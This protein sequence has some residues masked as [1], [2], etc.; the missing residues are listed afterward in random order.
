[1]LTI[2]F[3]QR[4]KTFG[5]KILRN[6]L[7]CEYN[8]IGMI[9]RTSNSDNNLIILEATGDEGVGLLSWKTF[10]KRNWQDLYYKISLRKLQVERTDC[11]L[12]KIESFIR[13]RINFSPEN[14]R[15]MDRINLTFLVINCLFFP[16]LV[17]NW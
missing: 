9:L 1:M 14:F 6:V 15:W 8:H 7:G 3:C 17:C 4:G 13:V 11:M 12:Q 2:F 10:I 5:E 16:S